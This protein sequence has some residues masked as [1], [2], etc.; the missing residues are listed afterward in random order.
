MKTAD[1]FTDPMDRLMTDTKNKATLWTHCLYKM[2]F[3]WKN[4]QKIFWSIIIPYSVY[5]MNL[6]FGFKI[7][8]NFFLHYKAVF[9]NIAS[10]ITVWVE[11]LE[12]KNIAARFNSI[13]YRGAFALIPRDS[14]FQ[15]LAN[16]FFCFFSMVF[17]KPSL[18]FVRNT[19]NKPPFIIPFSHNYIIA[20]H[21]RKVK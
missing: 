16:F 7:P 2:G 18:S 1:K 9:V 13:T 20:S 8:A 11:R 17:T 5:M 12:N 19:F 4:Q 3:P 14:A 15:G 10:F 6:L 21:R